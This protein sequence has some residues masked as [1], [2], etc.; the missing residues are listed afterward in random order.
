VY[1]HPEL[2]GGYSFIPVSIPGKSL[3]PKLEGIL[4]QGEDLREYVP[5][6]GWTRLHL[7]W[8]LDAYEKFPRKE[9]F[10]LPYFE[11]LAG[12]SDLRRQIVNGWSETAIR[13]TWQGDLEDFRVRRKNYLIYR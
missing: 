10:F 4:C 13:E 9:E 11:K 2:E 3:R 8:L 5:E 1:G 6:E 7:R 12:T